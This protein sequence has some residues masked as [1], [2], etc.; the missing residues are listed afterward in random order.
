MQAGYDRVCEEGEQK[1]YTYVMSSEF[2]SVEWS[3]KDLK[4]VRTC[5]YFLIG[6][7]VSQELIDSIYICFTDLL[8][9]S[10]CILN[11]VQVG[12]Y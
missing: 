6:L 11:G 4:Q 5:K 7:K 2:E 10:E 3:K 9:V 1:L 12:S 8:N